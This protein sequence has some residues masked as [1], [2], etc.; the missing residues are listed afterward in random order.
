MDNKQF[1]KNIKQKLSDLEGN[2]P[3]P[4][5]DDFSKLLSSESEFK[6]LSFD[7]VFSNALKDK[8]QR[9]NSLHWV[10]LKKRLQTEAKLR[11]EV[12]S[13]KIFEF[14]LIILLSFTFVNLDRHYN[15]VKEGQDPIAEA[16]Q[17]A[18]KYPEFSGLI[19][20]GKSKKVESLYKPVALLKEKDRNKE[21]FVF[22]PFVLP[23][24][25][26]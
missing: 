12:Y 23:E 14:I 15:L 3:P 21:T 20:M 25:H 9:F 1:D 22:V 2:A 6:D 4:D 13:T 10:Q 18:L 16:V 8:K 7:Q 19:P 26:L 17:D 24:S 5:W 11:K